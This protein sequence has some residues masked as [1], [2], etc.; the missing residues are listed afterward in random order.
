L[1]AWCGGGRPP[2]I[3]SGFA[4]LVNQLTITL[5]LFTLLPL[6]ASAGQETLSLNVNREKVGTLDFENSAVVDVLDLLAEVGDL[7]YIFDEN[8][9]LQATTTF[10]LTETPVVE[11]LSYFLKANRMFYVVRESTTVLIAPDT[12]DS[13]WRSSH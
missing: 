12:R 10:R 8:V 2:P 7:H 1:V 3:L 9:D 11:A 4:R 6:P 5:F 13:S